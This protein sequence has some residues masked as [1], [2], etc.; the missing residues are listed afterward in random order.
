MELLLWCD[1]W[2]NAWLSRMYQQY[3]ASE[4]MKID[5]CRELVL[6]YRYHDVYLWFNCMA[7]SPLVPT[8]SMVGL[9]HLPLHGLCRNEQPPPKHCHRKLKGR[10]VC[11][12]WT[13]PRHVAYLEGSVMAEKYALLVTRRYTAIMP[14]PSM[15]SIQN[16]NWTATSDFCS[17][18]PGMKYKLL[19][20]TPIIAVSII[21]L[22]VQAWDM[23]APFPDGL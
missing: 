18:N 20:N 2:C 23:F 10:A 17:E 4:T 15:P 13:S 6:A 1:L 19:V 7:I 14:I 3:G 8:S 21:S 22:S 16:S 11:D 12:G 5:G 9:T